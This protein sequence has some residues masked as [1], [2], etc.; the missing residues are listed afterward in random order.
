[1]PCCGLLKLSFQKVLLIPPEPA[2]G[3]KTIAPSGVIGYRWPAPGVCHPAICGLAAAVAPC[4]LEGVLLD[5]CPNMSMAVAS[6]VVA[7]LACSGSPNDNMLLSRPMKMSCAS[8][9]REIVSRTVEEEFGGCAVSSAA[10]YM[11]LSC[12]LFATSEGAQIVL[13]IKLPP[14]KCANVSFGEVCSSDG[15]YTIEPAGLAKGRLR[16][17]PAPHMAP[18]GDP[19]PFMAWANPAVAATGLVGSA[20]LKK[21]SSHSR[22]GFPTSSAADDSLPS[23]LGTLSESLDLRSGLNNRSPVRIA[24]RQHNKH[25]VMMATATTL[26]EVP[27]SLD[28]K[29]ASTPGTS[30]AKPESSPEPEYVAGVD[31][32]VV[33]TDVVSVVAA[34][35]VTVV[36]AVRVAVVVTLE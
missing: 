28:A 14:G 10:G 26:K 34:V 2:G 22:L 7:A 36:V 6:A 17:G 24:S 23:D 15:K 30:G 19:K 13:A 21:L 31:E 35:P 5:G 33:D 29:S 11:D 1:M 12:D 9:E 16:R 32:A 20:T 4:G 25:G 3:V 18:S 8:V 27:D